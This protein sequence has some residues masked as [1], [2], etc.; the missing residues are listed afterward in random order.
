MNKLE[1]NEQYLLED[2]LNRQLKLLE[3]H[4]NISNYNLEKIKIIQNILLKLDLKEWD[5]NNCY[6]RGIKYE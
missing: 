4:I 6:N 1:I 2:L 3:Q 5:Y